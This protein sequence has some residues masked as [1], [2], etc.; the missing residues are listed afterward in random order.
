[1]MRKCDSSEE[2]ESIVVTNNSRARDRNG[3][4]ERNIGAFHLPIVREHRPSFHTNYLCINFLLKKEILN[5]RE[6]LR[7]LLQFSYTLG[8]TLTLI[9]ACNVS[10][11]VRV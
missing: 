10:I 5:K 1:M 9:T 4:K 3:E 7:V 8:L 6:T 2:K 11:S